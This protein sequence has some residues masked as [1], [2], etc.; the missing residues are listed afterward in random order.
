MILGP[1]SR[2]EDY[3]KVLSRVTAFLKDKRERL[4]TLESAQEVYDLTLE[5]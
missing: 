5:Y 3:L 2:Q 1:D 4:L